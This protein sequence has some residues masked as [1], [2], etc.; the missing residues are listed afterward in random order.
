MFTAFVRPKIVLSAMDSFHF[1]EEWGQYSTE[2]GQW[3]PRMFRSLCYGETVWCA[4]QSE[5][6]T[7]NWSNTDSI[8]ESNAATVH[9]KDVSRCAKLQEE[10]R[11][12]LE[13]DTLALHESTKQKEQCFIDV[14]MHLTMITLM[15]LSHL[16]SQIYEAYNAK[17][18]QFFPNQL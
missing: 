1:E 16:L 7:I 15:L 5:L 2:T 9:F 10:Q 8:K 6:C 3:R 12:Q 13:R 17:A 18:I 11:K 14:W 4:Q